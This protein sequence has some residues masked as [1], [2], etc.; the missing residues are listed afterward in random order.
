MLESS[1]L[2]AAPRGWRRKPSFARLHQLPGAHDLVRRPVFQNN[3][4]ASVIEG[5]P[6]GG[7]GAHQSLALSLAQELEGAVMAKR[8]V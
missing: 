5:E 7:V 2:V 1:F 3:F 4:E 8:I 6:F